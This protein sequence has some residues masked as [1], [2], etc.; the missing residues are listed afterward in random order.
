MPIKGRDD[1]LGDFAEGDLVWVIDHDAYGV[2]T[3]IS[4]SGWY[5]TVCWQK[6][7]VQM[8]VP[9]NETTVQANVLTVVEKAEENS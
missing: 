1:Y 2:I 8:G 5:I 9:L 3:D 4:H 6:P 7:H